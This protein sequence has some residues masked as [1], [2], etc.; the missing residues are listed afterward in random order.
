M[1]YAACGILN[2]TNSSINTNDATSKSTSSYGGIAPNGITNITNSTI[3]GNKKSI[4]FETRLA[5]FYAYLGF[6]AQNSGVI[7]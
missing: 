4:L 2:I 1:L 7:T 6:M 3:C 5:V